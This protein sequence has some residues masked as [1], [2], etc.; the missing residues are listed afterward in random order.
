MFWQNF[1]ACL[2]FRVR[3]KHTSSEVQ[4]CVCVFFPLR[5]NKGSNA[6]FL[7]S[8][9]TIG[10]DESPRVP[11]DADSSWHL[12]LSLK[13]GPRIA[14]LGVTPSSSLI[15]DAPQNGVVPCRRSSPPCLVARFQKT[16]SIGWCVDMQ[17]TSAR[18]CSTESNSE[19]QKLRFPKN[20]GNF[21][22]PNPSNATPFRLG[23]GYFFS[24]SWRLYPLNK[25]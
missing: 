15:H 2:F 21:Q 4:W 18:Q 12:E 25:I 7:T 11:E 20:H 10:V 16:R 6:G 1:A 23:F 17:K 14:T 19:F 9:C 3:R 24:R 13:K 5:S 8:I 22:A